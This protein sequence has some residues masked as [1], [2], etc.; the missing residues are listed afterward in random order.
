MDL[1]L[2]LHLDLFT[3]TCPNCVFFFVKR[4]FSILISLNGMLSMDSV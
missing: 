4:K 1:Y 3:S 2:Y